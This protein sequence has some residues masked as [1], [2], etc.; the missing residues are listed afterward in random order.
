MPPNRLARESSP[1]LL[2]HAHNPVDW[3]PWGADA[4]AEARRRDVPIFLSIGYATCYWCHVMER[5]SFEDPDTARVLND[6]FLPVKL[7]R[8]ERPDLDDLYM[9]ATLVQRGHGGWPM[10]VFLDPASLRPFF[11]GTYFPREPA[12]NLPDFRAVLNAMSKAWREQ[13]EGVLAQA[14]AL[15]DAVRDHIE[16]RAA[17]ADLGD[18]PVADA[19]SHLLSTFDRAHGG[20]G[21]APKFPQPAIL[22]FLLDVRERAADDATTDAIEIALRTSLDAMA[23]GG[24]RDHLAG[25]F[26][27][28]CVDESW[29]V[30]HFEKMLPDSALLAAIYARAARYFNDAFYARVAHDTC[31]YIHTRMTGPDGLFWSAQ[32]AEVDG[33]E[34]VPYVWSPQRLRAAL[35]PPEVEQIPELRER[36]LAAVDFAARAYALDGPPN[37]RDPHHPDEPSAWV[38]RLA[39]HPDRLALRANMDPAEF[40]DRLTRV[41][42]AMLEYRDRVP[43]PLTDDKSLA[44]WNAVTIRALAQCAVDLET[45]AYRDA[46]SRAADAMLATMRTA[47]GQLLRA[48]RAGVS[49]IPAL[50]EDYAATIAA[51]GALASTAGSPA[52]RDRR[53]AQARALLAHARAAFFDDATGLLLDTR[54]DQPDLFARA[55][56][57][58]DGAL[59]SGFSQMLHALIDLADLTA[60]HAL[61]A[62]AAQ[63]LEANGARIAASPAS[64][65][66]AVRALFRLL[67]R[68]EHAPGA[69]RPAS[70]AEI[71][72]PRAAESQRRTRGQADVVKVFSP[73]ERVE[74]VPGTPAM[75]EVLVQIADG[76][77]V[78]AADPGDTPAAQAVTPFRID[79]LG[80][81]AVRCFADYP[82]GELFGAGEHAIR[83]YAGAVRLRVVLERAGDWRGVPRLVVAYQACSGS[84]C[85]APARAEL[86]IELARG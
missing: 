70:A 59:P 23:L 67:L 86:D 76:W 8:E 32:D 83:V 52:E 64:S 11:C 38:L 63:A 18:A 46:A 21:P 1:Y 60:D 27:R 15:A 42:G 75:V 54:A 62:R 53:V 2:Q 30:P 74:L 73:A 12:H 24:L 25:G 66:N 5:E 58:H 61:A 39:D 77:H 41:S 85:H 81:P 40:T 19:L 48:R 34:G 57:L 6:N 29:T 84:E 82:A 44:A 20:F 78:P 56:T 79:V 71:H 72:A 33:R 65:I 26:H 9:T 51:L 68:A 3:W 49:K 47:D 22:D 55:V 45:P 69:E 28:Y 80:N 10:S 50:L 4:F 17:P 37:F 43:Q 36:A 35:C 14:A 7:D 31:R 13:R 16:G